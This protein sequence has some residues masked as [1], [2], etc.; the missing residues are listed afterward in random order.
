[1]E[2]IQ[3][4]FSYARKDSEFVLK[5]ANELRATG[6]NL[7]LDQLDIRGGQHWDR[8]VEGALESCQGMLVVLSPESVASN[9]VMDEVSYALEEGKLVVP[10]LFRYCAIPFRLRRVQYVDLTEAWS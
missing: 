1:M 4:F 8:A 7:W 10:I 6:V 5:L 2:D 9:N 3:Y